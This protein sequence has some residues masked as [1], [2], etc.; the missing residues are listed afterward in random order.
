MAWDWPSS[1]HGPWAER[2]L[3][4][5]DHLRGLGLGQDVEISAA[6][7]RPDLDT[8]RLWWLRLR[9]RLFLRQP[10]GLDAV[11]VNSRPVTGVAET[12]SATS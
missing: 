7:K 2:L 4:R 9:P 11:T 12:E 3:S 6:G 5:R 8:R 10:L 1:D